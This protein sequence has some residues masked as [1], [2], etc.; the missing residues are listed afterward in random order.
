MVQDKRDFIKISVFFRQTVTNESNFANIDGYI[1]YVGLNNV[2][3][4]C[5]ILL[6]AYPA[7]YTG[8]FHC[9]CRGTS[10]NDDSFLY[11]GTAK[12]P[13]TWGRYPP[14]FHYA[15]HNAGGHYR[16]VTAGLYPCQVGSCARGQDGSGYAGGFFRP[17]SKA[18]F[19]LF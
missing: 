6:A 1:V 13:H 2:E 16:Q 11:K 10:G 15:W 12:K 9:D 3:K 7:V 14:Y 18:Q 19:Q 5:K 17:S 8:Y 4:I